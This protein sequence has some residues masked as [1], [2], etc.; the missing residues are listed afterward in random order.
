V[1]FAA[2]IVWRLYSRMRRLVGRQKMAASRAWT[3]IVVFAL[4]LSV[5]LASSI[6]RPLSAAALATGVAL[7]VALG[8]YGLRMTRFEVEAA[9]YFYT[10]SAHLGIGLSLLVAD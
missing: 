6:A 2:L 9:G 5:L 8:L 1:G 3:T 4:L 7:G 10:P